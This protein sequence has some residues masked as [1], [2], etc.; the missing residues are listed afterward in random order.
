MNGAFGVLAWSG[1]PPG[2]H[3]G[4]WMLPSIHSYPS[5]ANVG[6]KLPPEAFMALSKRHSNQAFNFFSAASQSVSG[7]PGRPLAMRSR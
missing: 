4:P 2:S 5:I 3:G 6:G 7:L 1:W